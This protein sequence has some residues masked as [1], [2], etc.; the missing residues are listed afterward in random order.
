MPVEVGQK[1]PN[2]SLIAT[3]RTPV[4]LADLLGRPTVLLFFPGAFTGVCTKEMCTV[5]DDLNRFT[6]A[7]AQVLAVSVDSPFAQHAF[8]E[9][10]GL[11]FTLLS[12]FQRDAVKAFGV[13]DPNFLKGMMAGTAK[14]SAF[15]V[16]SSGTVTYRWVSDNPGVEPNYDEV[17]DA[18]RRVV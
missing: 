7:G 11:T 18:V 17:A 6:E 2:V 8:K 1:V 10:H 15:V 4:Q 12:D 3:D 9:A 13:E 5:R 16:D 14:R